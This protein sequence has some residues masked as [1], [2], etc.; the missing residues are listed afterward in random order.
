M[1]VTLVAPLSTSVSQLSTQGGLERVSS[2]WWQWALLVIR[3]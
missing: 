3:V 1:A 2:G